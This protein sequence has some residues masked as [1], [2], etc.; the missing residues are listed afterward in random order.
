MKLLDENVMKKF[1]TSKIFKAYLLK[2]AKGNKNLSIN[3]NSI[4]YLIH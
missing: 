4:N 2:M 3:K 1:T